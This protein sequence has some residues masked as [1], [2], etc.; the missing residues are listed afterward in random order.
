MMAMRIIFRSFPAGRF[1]RSFVQFTV[2]ME[3]LSINQ[4]SM[5]TG[6][7]SPQAQVRKIGLPYAKILPF[8]PPIP[9]A[10]GERAKNRPLIQAFSR[11]AFPCYHA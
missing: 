6:F 10:A 9:E 1:K 5:R 3:A 4:F 8:F 2:T 11:Y 7:P